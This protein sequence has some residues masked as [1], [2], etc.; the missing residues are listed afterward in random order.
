MCGT[1]DPDMDECF[2]W[3]TEDQMLEDMFYEEEVEWDDEQAVR[4]LVSRALAKDAPADTQADRAIRSE[5]VAPRPRRRRRM[6]ERCMAVAEAH[7][8]PGIAV[9]YRGGLSETVR[10]DRISVPRPVTRKSLYIY[11]RA[12]GQIQLGHFYASGRPRHTRWRRYFEAHQWAV[13]IMRQDGIEVPEDMVMRA[14]ELVGQLMPRGR[15]WGS[16]RVHYWAMEFVRGVG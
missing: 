1:P 6:A 13:T 9:R 15:V 8:P 12:C 2:T 3:I 7:T 14:R 10:P 5:P 16:R 11:L 4:D